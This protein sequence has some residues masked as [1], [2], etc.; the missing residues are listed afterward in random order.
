MNVSE[1]KS[2]G[3]LR[4]YEILVTAS[5]IELE[6]AKKLEE[7]TKELEE[8]RKAARPSSDDLPTYAHYTQ[9]ALRPATDNIFGLNRKSGFLV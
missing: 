4:E 1:T 5:E 6:A 8:A 3:L 9:P 2:D 7:L